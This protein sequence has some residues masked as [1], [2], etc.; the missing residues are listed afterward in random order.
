MARFGSFHELVFEVSS[1]RILTFTDYKR[2][3]AHRYVKH[4]IHNYKPKLESVGNDL[5]EVELT[6]KFMVSLGVDPAAEV[7]KLRKMVQNAV[8]DYLIIGTSVIGESPF[9]IKEISEEV[10]A[11]DGAGKIL[12][13]TVKVVFNEYVIVGDF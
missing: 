13:S 8:A 12:A 6:I 4:E 9:V 1:F 2:K 7:E 10:N 5:E 3:T 11:W